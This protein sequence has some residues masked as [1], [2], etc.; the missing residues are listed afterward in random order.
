[1]S[2]FGQNKINATPAVQTI[3]NA[4]AMRAKRDDD[5]SRLGEAAIGPAK[6]RICKKGN[7]C[8]LAAILVIETVS[9]ILSVRVYIA[10]YT[11]SP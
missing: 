2:R 4:L 1:M 5:L 3:G 8:H 10:I 6:N 7:I 11:R 9:A